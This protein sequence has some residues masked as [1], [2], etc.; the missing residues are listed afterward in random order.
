MSSG[1]KFCK[2]CGA[3]TE[4]YADGRCKPCIRKKN[5]KWAQDNKDKV[6]AKSRRWNANNADAKRQTNAIYRERAKDQINTRRKIARQHDKS[7]ERVKSAKR[8]AQKRAGGGALSKNIVELLLE[9]QQGL[10][11]CCNTPLNGLFHLDHKIPLSRGGTN[12]N[13]NVQL[14]LPAC[15]MQKSTKTFEEFIATR[16]VK[17][18]RLNLNGGTNGPTG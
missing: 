4:R 10:C 8:R 6:N 1:Q 11:A 7:L 9:L 2:K 5:A 15:N 16:R 12:T 17:I 13:D 18:L 14:L 3:E